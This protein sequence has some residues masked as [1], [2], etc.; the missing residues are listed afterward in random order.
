M[1]I[2][3][4]IGWERGL[5]KISLTKLVQEATASD[6]GEAKHKVDDLLEGRPFEVHLEEELRAREFAKQLKAVGAILE[7]PFD[8]PEETT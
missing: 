3:R 7:R 4:V 1:P 2:V 8:S 5:K 6:L